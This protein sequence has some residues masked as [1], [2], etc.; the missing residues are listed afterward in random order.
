MTIQN[1][2]VRD[3][4]HWHELRKQHIGA[5]EVA[6]IM[7]L[8]KFKTKWRL[9]HEKRGTLPPENLDKD[10]AVLTGRHM[11]PALAKW[12]EAKFD[13]PLRK[14]H[15]YISDPDIRAGAS[16]DYETV[17]APRAPVEVKFS[18][19][20][21]NADP[22]YQWDWDGE[23]ITQA[24]VS[25]LIQVQHQMML[26]G[27]PEAWLVA[28]VG[29]SVRRMKVPRSES[30]I[31]HLRATIA[32]FWKDIEAGVEPPVDWFEDAD[33][34]AKLL[35]RVDPSL[36]PV[37]LNE[38]EAVKVARKFKLAKRMEERAK[39]YIAECKGQLWTMAGASSTAFVDGIKFDLGT[40]PD[41]QGT[42][43][44]ESMVGTYVGQRS[45]YRRCQI[46]PVSKKKGA[47]SQGG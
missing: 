31:E 35:S 22:N 19:G 42:L 3:D 17:E 13:W 45:G 5:S 30:I 25:Y 32:Q 6:C 40:N 33:G 12:A 9:W 8:S 18:T 38:P 2:E 23:H 20:F 21:G 4:A 27:A 36:P 28:Y 10:D 44:T 11:E 14:V 24:P 1:I 29:S 39:Q 41:T 47:K 34:I 37:D 7:G 46:R 43:V 16:L 26:T 15:R